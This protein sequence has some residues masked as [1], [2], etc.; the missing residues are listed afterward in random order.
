MVKQEKKCFDYEIVREGGEIN[1]VINTIG[2][3]FYPSLEDSGE[4]MEKTINLLIETGAVTTITYQA[5]RNYIYPFEQVKFLNE[6]ASVYVYLIKQREILKKESI[7]LD[8]PDCQKFY[9]ELLHTIRRIVME[10]LKR[11]PVGAYVS[12]IRIKREKKAQ[13]ELYESKYKKCLQKFIAVLDEIIERLEKTELIKLAKP[14]LP[15]YKVGNR[16]IYFKFFEPL[17]RPNFMFTR[18]QAEPPTMAEEIATYTIG[19]EL[20]STVSILKLPNQVR[21]RYHVLSPEFQLAEDEYVLLDEARQIIS[22]YKPKEEEF[23]DPER[24]RSIFF[25]IAKDLITQVAKNKGIKISYTKVERLAKLLVR[26]TV[27]FGMIE[28]LLSDPKVEDIY[29]N[30]PI[31]TLPIYI[32]HAEYG[33]CETNIIPQRREADSWASRFRMI[34]GRPLDEANPV[35]DTELFIP[36][37]ARARTAII[38]N[39]LS[40]GGYSFAFR[41]HR[42]RPWTLPLFIHY[43]TLSKEAAGL[44]S[45][46]IDGARSM[47]IAG[48]RG[49]GKTSLLGAL[50]VEIMRKFR[51]ITVED[52]LELPVNYMRNIGYNILPMKVRSAIVGEKA[53]LSAE[54]G[55]RTSLRLGDS[56]LIVGEVRSTEARAL[57]EAMR[58]G[59][60]ANVVAGTIH[61]DSPYGVFDRVVNDLG[62]P[63]TS[64]KATDIV[65]VAGKLRTPDQMREIRR[66]THI[67]EIRKT[68]EED[69]LKEGG[70]MNLMEYD[71]KEDKIVP[72]RD[73]IEGESEVVKSIASKVRAW[74]GKWDLVWDNIVL[75]GEIKDML[76]KYAEKTGRITGPNGLLEADFVVEANDIF[77][78]IFDNLRE[79]TGYPESKEVLREFE[80]WLKSRIKKGET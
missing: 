63:R 46:L 60:L 30:A 50:M 71:A 58:V 31:G 12:A 24:M 79:E 42:E 72:T 77:H 22:R 56:A 66:T 45:F 11:D 43:K 49:A 65:V 10:Q 52:T 2:C 25:N 36:N 74:V 26:L 59:A 47:L 57:Y 34:S 48:T 6:I 44:L 9:P 37:V 69:P 40:P 70:F 41:Q 27:G 18:L 39:P 73:L 76:R 53:E 35:L 32:K 54:D 23:I 29:I 68:W 28:V 20:K 19:K 17:I 55:I 78:R 1:L 14:Y 33:E 80:V 75:R 38:Q 4:C 16:D 21:L 3:P 62:V 64:F 7:G 8:S 51:I 5:E 15:G 13:M 61:G 67:T